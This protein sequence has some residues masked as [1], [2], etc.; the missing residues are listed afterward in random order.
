MRSAIL[1][2][3]AG[4]GKTRWGPCSRR[5]V[6]S[7]TTADLDRILAFTHRFA[8]AQATEVVD[9]PW[10]FVLLQH[11]YPGSHDHN[12]L[13]VTE[14]T[15]AAEIVGAMET[16]LG[17]AAMRHRSVTIEAGPIDGAVRDDFL[18]AGYEEESL[19]VM[20]HR[21][22]G[23]TAPVHDVSEITIDALRP[24]L[25]RDWKLNLPDSSAEVHRQLADR[26]ELYTRSADVT[27]AVVLEGD[28]IAA[29]SD[30]FVDR[31]QRIA[32]FENL[33]THPDH[34]GKGYASSLLSASLGKAA[35]E[36][37]DLVFLSAVVG[38]WPLD[39]YARLGFVEVARTHSFT[40]TAL[41]ANRSEG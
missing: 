7:V 6:C 2:G 32:Q 22:A 38:D 29:R 31:A 14:T 13:V 15:A 23:M 5:T 40:R 17:G 16:H 33:S 39:W 25:L 24:A 20:V 35:S 12:R 36:G 10:G 9:L 34:R 8:R 3:V 27:H 1:V 18:T 41:T 19:A 11:D 21:G 26:T 37:C 30:L 28:A 4:H